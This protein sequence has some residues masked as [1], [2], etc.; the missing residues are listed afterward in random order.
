[1]I[2][3]DTPITCAKYQGLNERLLT[4]RLPRGDLL[5]T[6]AITVDLQSS[7]QSS[8]L[9][10]ILRA[11]APIHLRECRLRGSGLGLQS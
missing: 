2:F 6:Q 9:A 5:V 11:L 10:E 7:P 8:F 4:A 3:I 1:M